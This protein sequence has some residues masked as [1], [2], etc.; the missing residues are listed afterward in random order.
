MT[1]DE[2]KRVGRVICNSGDAAYLAGLLGDEFPEFEWTVETAGP[3]ILGVRVK[4]ACS[5]RRDREER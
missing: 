5:P 4:K 3:H 1:L 2:A